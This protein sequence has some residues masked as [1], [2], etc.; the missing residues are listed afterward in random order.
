MV[1]TI[2]YFRYPSGDYTAH[3]T[4]DFKKDEKTNRKCILA[5]NMSSYNDNSYLSFEYFYR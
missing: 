3:F 5:Y 1:V 2:L 4:P